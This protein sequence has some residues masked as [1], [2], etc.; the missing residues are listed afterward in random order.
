MEDRSTAP[1]TL[2]DL[3]ALEARLTVVSQERLAPVLTL[4]AE[5][6]QRHIRD[7]YA[8]KI[9]EAYRGL[10]GALRVKAFGTRP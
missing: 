7:G 1:A 3:D 6:I 9:N 5:E 8:R 4:T 2:A 10:S